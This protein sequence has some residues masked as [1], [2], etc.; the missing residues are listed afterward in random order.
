MI[1]GE[2]F[3]RSQLPFVPYDEYSTL[4]YFRYCP[5]CGTRLSKVEERDIL[6]SNYVVDQGR[7][8]ELLDMPVDDA[9]GILLDYRSE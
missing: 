6:I 5:E 4:S 3:F 1:H 2:P 8:R 7:R 9:I